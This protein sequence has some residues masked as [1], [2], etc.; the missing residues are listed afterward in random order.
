MSCSSSAGSQISTAIFLWK[1]K[2][3]NATLIYLIIF[4]WNWAIWKE[5]REWAESLCSQLQLLSVAATAIISALEVLPS[6]L[7]NVSLSVGMNTSQIVRYSL[8]QSVSQ[9]ASCN[10]GKYLKQLSALG[11]IQTK[12]TWIRRYKTYSHQQCMKCAT[13]PKL[14]IIYVF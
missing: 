12:L 3:I 14:H 5:P 2:W 6:R 10:V 1:A 7:A 4:H 11:S 9:P 8:S 13:S